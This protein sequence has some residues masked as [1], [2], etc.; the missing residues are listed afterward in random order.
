MFFLVSQLRKQLVQKVVDEDL[1]NAA[2]LIHR[3]VGFS[4]EYRVSEGLEDPLRK[5]GF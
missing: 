2:Q 4:I 5:E 1:L 3:R